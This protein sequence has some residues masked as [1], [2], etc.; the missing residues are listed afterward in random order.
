M[1]GSSN[2]PKYPP[3]A[4]LNR[5]QH[6]MCARYEEPFSQYYADTMAYKMMREFEYQ[7][8]ATFNFIVKVRPDAP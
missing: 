3:A 8:A 6:R 2:K 7:H 5:A 1:R 4:P